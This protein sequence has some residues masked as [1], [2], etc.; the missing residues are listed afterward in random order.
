[1]LTYQAHLKQIIE[2]LILEEIEMKKDA[3]ITA[4]NVFQF[5]DY[6]FNVGQVIGL[7]RAL[8]LISEAETIIE[9]GERG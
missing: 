5:E 6:K 8:E 7:Q 4:H 9:K 3:L 1:M 2:S